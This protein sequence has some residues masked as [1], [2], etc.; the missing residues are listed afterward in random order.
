MQSLYL[1]KIAIPAVNFALVKPL[2]NKFK[3]IN[4]LKKTDIYICK[5]IDVNS[6]L[7]Q[8]CENI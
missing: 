1:T 6:K 5:K 7:C 2:L 3:I 8:K 4:P